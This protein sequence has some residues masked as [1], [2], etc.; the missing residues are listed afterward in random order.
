MLRSPFAS[1]VKSELVLP[2]RTMTSQRERRKRS[3]IAPCMPTVLWRAMACEDTTNRGPLVG[4]KL[5]VAT[6]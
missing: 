6:L 2:A 5:W 4:D 1:A 3:T